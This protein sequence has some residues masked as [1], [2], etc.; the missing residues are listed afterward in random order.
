MLV[1][2]IFFIVFSAVSKFTGDSFWK[3]N[4]STRLNFF[5]RQ[6][7]KGNMTTRTTNMFRQ[8]TNPECHSGSTF[9]RKIKLISRKIRI[10]LKIKRYRLMWQYKSNNTLQKVP[11]LKIQLRP[12]QQRLCQYFA[13][14]PTWKSLILWKWVHWGWTCQ[15]CKRRTTFGNAW[16]PKTRKNAKTC[17][18]RKEKGHTR[19]WH[20]ESKRGSQIGSLIKSDF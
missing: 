12:I 3:W 18:I 7:E 8:Y 9:Q 1:F 17:R 10:E 11:Q 6:N 4:S 5:M 2:T 20:P 14:K 15:G 13:L 19:H 16:P